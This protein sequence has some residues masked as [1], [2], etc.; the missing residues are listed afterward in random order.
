V[1]RSV[2]DSSR[3]YDVAV[4]IETHRGAPNQYPARTDRLIEEFPNVLFCAELSHCYTEVDMVYGDIES[5]L[6]RLAPV[7]VGYGMT[8]GRI[9]D[10][11]C[12][13]VAVETDDEPPHVAHFRRTWA[14]IIAETC[15][16]GYCELPFMGE[17][18]PVPVNYARKVER[19]ARPEEESARWTQEEVPWRIFNGLK[20]ANDSSASSKR[21]AHQEYDKRQPT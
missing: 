17:L 2:E 15:I 12:I 3:S 20:G 5:K 1:S 4:L 8:N 16:D 14:T 18:L 7:F 19:R 21:H 6:Q 9:S 10:P 13:Q 11:E